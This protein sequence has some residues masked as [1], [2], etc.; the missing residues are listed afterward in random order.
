MKIWKHLSQIALAALIAGPGILHAT[1]VLPALDIQDFSGDVGATLTATTFDIDATAF[2]IITGGGPIDISD[3][4]FALSSVGSYDGSLGS[5]VGI[6]TV[7][8]GALSGTLTDLSVISLG[9]SD[10]QF[11]GDVTYT[12]GSLAGSLIGGRIEGTLSG[13]GVAAEL[14]PISI[15]PIPTALWL[16]GSGLLGLV[17][18]ARRKEA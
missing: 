18:M 15:V 14:G 3:L 9:G 16:F 7:S 5:F 4:S 11:G 2:T 13:S 1:V 17:G 12:G 10:I 6:F 8:G